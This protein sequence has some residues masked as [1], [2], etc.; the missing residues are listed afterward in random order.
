MWFSELDDVEIGFRVGL[1]PDMKES[2]QLLQPKLNQ[3][4][5]KVF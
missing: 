1:L 4:V 5:T 3:E 2:D